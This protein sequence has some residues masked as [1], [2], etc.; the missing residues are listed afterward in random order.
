MLVD[1]KFPNHH[2]LEKGRMKKEGTALIFLEGFWFSVFVCL[3]WIKPVGKFQLLI[4]T[5]CYAS[6]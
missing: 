6:L 1:F 3:H 2:M 4:R 5:F